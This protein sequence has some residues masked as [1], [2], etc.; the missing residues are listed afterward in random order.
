MSSNALLEEMR[1]IVGDEGVAQPVVN[2]L[3]LSSLLE[4]HI[5]TDDISEKVKTLVDNP[6]I[7]WYLR[8]KTKHAVA[9]IVSAFAIL[10]V[11]M[12]LYRPVIEWV[13]SIPKGVIP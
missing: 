13:A 7:I 12:N 8:Y 5:A 6:S 9:V 2:R 4:L 1:R 10:S 11:L 3:V